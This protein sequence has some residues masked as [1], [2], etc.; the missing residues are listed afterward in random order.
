MICKCAHHWG[1][2]SLLSVIL[3]TQG[4]GA[5][6]INNGGFELFE[7]NAAFDINTPTDW[8]HENFTAVVSHFQPDRGRGSYWKIS[9]LFPYKGSYFLVLSTGDVS[10]EPDHAKVQQTITVSA[11]NTL[12]GA[13]F[14][15]AYDYL[16]YND[17][18]EIRLTPVA[19]P[20]L[21]ELKLVHVAVSD[22]GSYGSMKSWER[23]A[24]TFEAN[25]AGTYNLTIEVRDVGDAQVNSYLAVDGLVLCEN[26]SGGGDINLDCTT[27]FQDFA[28]LAEDWLCDCNNPINYQD[29]NNNCQ[30]G[31]D[32]TGDGFIDTNDLEIMSQYWLEGVKEP[33]E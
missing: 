15:G 29:P 28:L 4:F 23:F 27:D 18:G 13:Y 26:A 19:D 2:I 11:G 7:Y 10:P 1:V 6:D 20:N 30:F 25:Q 22:V 9:N 21:H 14:F 16:P 8:Q 5:Y 32:L 3:T 17:Y 31:I 24:H 12:I 33:E